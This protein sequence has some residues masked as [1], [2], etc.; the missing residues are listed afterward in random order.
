MDI[1]LTSQGANKQIRNNQYMAARP[2]APA[3]PCLPAQGRGPRGWHRYGWRARWQRAA[4]QLPHSNLGAHRFW[5]SVGHWECEQLSIQGLEF[6]HYSLCNPK[7]KKKTQ[8]PQASGYQTPLPLSLPSPRAPLCRQRGG[9]LSGNVYGA[10][11]LH[12]AFKEGKWLT[13]V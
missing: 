13:S 8:L 5:S 2:S 1:H 12:P 4:G 10:D 6:L 7:K 9:H 11:L 3:V